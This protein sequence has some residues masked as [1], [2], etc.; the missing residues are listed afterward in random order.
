MRQARYGALLTEAYD[1]DKPHA[2][3]DELAFYRSVVAGSGQPVL[4]AMC[5]SGRFLVPLVAEGIDVEGVDA[6]AD[7]LA[8]CRRRAE[9]AGVRPVLRQG[10]VQ[11]LS[12]EGRYRT[13]FCGGGSFGLLADDGDVTSALRALHR[14]LAPG[15]TVVLEVETPAAAGRPGAWGGRWWRRP[16]GALIVLRGLHGGVRDGVEE[17]LGIYELYV[18]GVLVETELDEWVRRFWTADAITDALTA[19]GFVDVRVTRAFSDEPPRG[20]DDTMLSV[21]ARRPDA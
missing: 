20:A 7:M 1:I 13:A 12:D 3:P 8:A 14:A 18:D 10:L 17:A 19:A 15:G 9:D 5:G 21:R 11:E 6:S 2:P 4:E 16:D